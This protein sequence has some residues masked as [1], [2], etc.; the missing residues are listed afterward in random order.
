[1]FFCIATFLFWQFPYDDLSEVV[2]TLVAEKTNNQVFLQFDRLGIQVFPYPALAVDN[3]VVDSG[4]LPSIQAAKLSFAPSISGLISF[5]PGFTAGIKQVWDGDINLT[6]K[7]GKK[8]ELGAAT[9]NIYLDLEQIQ[10]GQAWEAFELPLKLRGE[11]SGE[12][13][14]NLD[15]S[16][17]TPPEGNIVL[18]V[19]ELKF[20]SGA[21]PTQMG[22]VILPALSW[23][24]TQLKGRLAGGKMTLEPSDF[25]A[26]GDS[27]FGS[28]K[29]EI[30]CRIE[31]GDGLTLGAYK[32]QME[33][34][35]TPKVEREL[36]PF[37][38]LL[39]P[40]KSA[41]PSGTKYKFKVTGQRFGYA[42]SFSAAL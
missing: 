35:V 30:D 32:L 7:A 3:V 25:G 36:A 41:T 23:K 34:L 22:P 28:I 27:L 38:I 31:P 9:Q 17:T 26:T 16:F 39:S 4:F 33:F 29:G 37:L 12:M 5:H 2:S 20:P 13:N 42:P 1:M 40:Y 6:L 14:V 24:K 15:P 18:E 10:L 21:I 8:T 19:K 11:L